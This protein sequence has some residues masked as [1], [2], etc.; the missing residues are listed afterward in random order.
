[1][2]PA[3]VDGAVGVR[4]GSSVAIACSGGIWSSSSGGMP[5]RTGGACR[6]DIA[7]VTGGERG[8][9]DFQCSSGKRSTGPFSGRPS[10]F[11]VRHVRIAA[12]LQSGCRPRLPV[13]AAFHVMAGSN[14]IV[15][16]P[17]RL[18]AS[19]SVGQFPVLQVGGVGLRMRHG[20]HAVF[21]K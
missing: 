6:L 9:P 5:R 8:G 2:A 11:I 21:T 3:G 7:H 13:G 19:L 18:S 10:P 4:D 1:V 14:R 20:F 15:R 16:E 17:R 12:S